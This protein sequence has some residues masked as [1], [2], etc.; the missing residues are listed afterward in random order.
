[1]QRHCKRYRTHHCNEL[2][3][4]DKGKKVSL[5]GWVSKIRLVGQMLGFIDLRDR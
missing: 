5:V 3:V 4:A 2:R 1:M